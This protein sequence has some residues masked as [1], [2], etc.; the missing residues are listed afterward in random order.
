MSSQTG[1]RDS[2][3]SEKDESTSSFGEQPMNWQELAAIES[4]VLGEVN[5]A[6][7][8][9]S[10]IDSATINSI[11]DAVRQLFVFDRISLIT[12]APATGVLCMGSSSGASTFEPGQTISLD[13]KLVSELLDKKS[14]NVF[15]SVGRNF[16]LDAPN[17]TTSRRPWL[18]KRYVGVTPQR[19]ITGSTR[20]EGRSAEW[21]I[22]C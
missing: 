19:G 15:D 17:K 20:C 7:Q 12:S 3:R 2:D 13:A 4:R 18:K 10:T 9:S 1:K 11:A 8:N 6:I 14:V 22:V 16:W 5:A 21:N